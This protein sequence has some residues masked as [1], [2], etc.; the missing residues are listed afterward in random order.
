MWWRSDSAL[1]VNKE[2]VDVEIAAKYRAAVLQHPLYKLDNISDA[3]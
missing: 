3:L 1:S 2:D